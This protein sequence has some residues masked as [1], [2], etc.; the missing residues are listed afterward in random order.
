MNFKGY[1]GSKYQNQKYQFDG[2]TFDS[3]KEGR[4]YA[5]LKMLER[6]GIIHDLQTQVPFI[7]IPAQYAVV[8]GKKKCIER[9]CKYIADFVYY[10]NGELVVED[11]KSEATKTKDYIIKRKLLLYVHHLRIKEV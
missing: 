10:E 4:R 7:L 8:D 6:G 11:T 9:E 2:L 5:E 1:N 3:R